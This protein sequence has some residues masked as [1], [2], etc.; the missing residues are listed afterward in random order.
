MA[1]GQLL[2]THGGEQGDFYHK[3]QGGSHSTQG[4]ECSRTLGSP[5]IGSWK[6]CLGNI[7][8]QNIHLIIFFVDCS[9]E[10]LTEACCPEHLRV[11][12]TV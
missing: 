11:S 2:E 10:D 7:I 1:I 4:Q 8:F 6:H 3:L 12:D 9:L 5:G